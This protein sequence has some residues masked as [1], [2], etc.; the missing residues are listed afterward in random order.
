MTGSLLYIAVRVALP[1]GA[2]AIAVF[3]FVVWRRD[4]RLRGQRELLRRAYELGEEILGAS[5]ADQILRKVNVVVPRIFGVTSAELY[6]YNRHAKSL[7]AVERNGT[8][9][10]S[11]PLS[12]PPAGPQAGAVAC[13]HYRTL[14][15]IPDTSRSPFP[16]SGNYGSAVPRSLLFIPMLAQ[17]EVLGILQMDQ[18]DRARVFSHEEQTLAQHLAN[19]IGVAVK[20]LDQRSVREQLFRTEK[21][22]AVGQLISGIV[23]DLRTPL[24]AINNLA[25]TG[26]AA[27]GLAAIAT[28]AQRASEIVERLVG[29]A[30]T[31]QAQNQPVELNGLLRNLIE[32]RERE[33]KVRGI[34]TRISLAD[35]PITVLGSHGQLEQVFLNL[36]VHA[37]QALSE[38]SEKLITI[39][40]SLVARRILVEIGFSGA[41]GA[42]PFV[43]GQ[44]EGPGG[45]GLAICRSLITGHGG[46]I[47]LVQQ[48]AADPTFQVALPC[49]VRER[50]S[51]AAAENGRESGQTL[52]ALVIEPAEATQMQLRGLLAVRGYRVVPVNSSDEGLDLAQRLR[53]DVIFC[54]AHAPGLNWVETSEQLKPRVGGFVLLS[55]A[56]NAELAADFAGDRR[57]VLAKPVDEKQLDRVLEAIQVGCR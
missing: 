31:G 28:E 1:L 10:T 27:A 43:T 12:A 35:D 53:F 2:F 36:L 16:V 15:A 17:G 8:E 38:S 4:E 46:E 18:H 33:W 25:R 41:K 45:A 32:F 54:S 30:G 34:H 39:R 51:G 56:F 52:T 20:L 7:D 22:A 37:E 42:D 48:A 40:T 9:Q 6:L 57:F 26:D 44:E 47:R 55:D 24:A 29:F 19:Q 3:I 50:T 21:L 14:L 5:S 49:A 13:F 23:N 11:I